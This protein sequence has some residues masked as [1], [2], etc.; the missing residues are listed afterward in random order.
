MLPARAKNY[1]LSG[2]EANPNVLHHLLKDLGAEDARWDTRPDP[3]RFTLR[4]MVAHLA[5]WEPINLMRL[6]RMRDEENP[7]IPDIDEGEIAIKNNYAASDPIASVTQYVEGRK[8]V[9][10]FLREL[11]EEAWQRI[12][13]REFLG[14]M[15]IAAQATLILGHDGYHLQQT[16]DWL[17]AS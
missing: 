8:A 16:L 14:E 10:A 13:Q 12:A 17:A 7:F 2:L 1:L 4:E 9:V 5:D 11:P 15:D 6:T 3:E